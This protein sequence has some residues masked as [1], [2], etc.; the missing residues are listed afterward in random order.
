MW[1]YGSFVLALALFAPALAQGDVVAPEPDFAQWFASPHAL[2]AVVLGLVSFL[3]KHFLKGLDGLAVP[4]VALV[5]ALALSA[6]G[7]ALGFLPAGQNWLTFGLQ[8]GVE[9]VLVVSGFRSLLGSVTSFL[10][11]GPQ[12]QGPAAPQG[13][14]V[15]PLS[16]PVSRD[17]LR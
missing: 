17:R 7:G 13:G 14:S 5:L 1:F 4:V 3:R 6:L 8:A 9:A 2:A 12:G 16:G 15:Q 10:G 11:N